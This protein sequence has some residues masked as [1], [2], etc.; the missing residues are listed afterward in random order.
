MAGGTWDPTSLPVR[1]GLYI[2]FKSA[3]VAQIKGGTRGTV[4]IPLKAITGG[5]ASVKTFYTVENETDATALFGASNIASIKYALQGGAREVLVYTL[6]ASATATD[7]LDARTAFDTR[8]FN[9][10]VFDGEVTAPIQDST[11]TWVTANRAAGKHFLAVFGAVAAADDQTPA[12]G[13]A[14]SVRLLDDYAVNVTVGT[15]IN[16]SAVSSGVYAPYVAGLIA[17]TPINRSITYKVAPVADVNKRYTNSEVVAALA[18]GSL[19]LTNDGEKVK[20]EQGLVTSVKKI[21]SMR[22]RQAISNDITKTAADSYIGQINNDADGQAALISAVKAY[23]ETLEDAG[24]LRAISVGL[25]PQFQSVGD[26]VY[27]LISYVE[28]DSM[29]RIF[30]TIS[31]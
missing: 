6:P 15:V 11:L 31:V 12:T 4:A 9:V 18:A 20:V 30:L 10:H 1:P 17:G 29:E 25:D 28:I 7:Y 13:N 19:V 14:R 24:V 21:R 22:A 23:L 8:P 27:L 16:G 5:T 3:A 26:R 2:N